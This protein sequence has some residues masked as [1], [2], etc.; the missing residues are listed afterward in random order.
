MSFEWMNNG[1]EV[2]YVLG[3]DGEGVELFK[4]VRCWDGF[5]SRSAAYGAQIISYEEI[6]EQYS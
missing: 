1:T 5:E 4:N 3:T 2:N 6:V